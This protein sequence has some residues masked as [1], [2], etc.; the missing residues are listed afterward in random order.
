MRRHWNYF[1]CALALG[2][3]G[4]TFADEKWAWA[5]NWTQNGALITGSEG[6][7]NKLFLQEAEELREFEFEVQITPRQADVPQS[8]KICGVGLAQS[9]DAF[10][11]LNLVEQPEA[12]GNGRFMEMKLRVSGEE[13]N[14]N[15]PCLA[16]SSFPW[17]YHTAYQFKLKLVDEKI[18]GWISDGSG[19]LGEFGFDLRSSPVRSGTPFLRVDG[20]TADFA[21]P[22][23]RQNRTQLLTDIDIAL[24]MAHPIRNVDP[25]MPEY[26]QIRLENRSSAPRNVEVQL[27]LEDYSGNVQS[28]ALTLELAPRLSHTV[29]LPWQ[30]EKL[31][32]YYLY[33]RIYDAAAN[34]AKEGRLSFTVMTP[35]PFARKAGDFRFGVC[36]HIVEAK[37][38]L[39]EAEYEALAESMSGADFVR[40][41][42]PWVFFQPEKEMFDTTTWDTYDAIFAAHNVEQMH[43]IGYTPLWAIAKGYKPRYQVPGCDETTTHYALP[44]YDAYE[45]FVKLLAASTKGRVTYFE[46]WNEPDINFFS[47]FTT[48]EYFELQKR[49]Y[50]GI[51]AGNPDA[52]V[53]TGGFAGLHLTPEKYD[54]VQRTAQEMRDYFDVFTIHL[55]GTF[56]S[57]RAQIP[58]MLEWLK[59]GDGSIAP[60]YPHETGMPALGGIEAER[61][62]ART[63][64]KKLLYSWA[65]GAVGYSWYD[66]RDDG[67]DPYSTEHTFGLITMDF[68]PKFVFS[69]FHMLARTLQGAR[70]KRTLADDGRV[71]CYLF[72]QGDALLIPAWTESGKALLA[73][74]TDATAVESIDLMGNATALPVENGHVTLNCNTEPQ[75]IR[76]NKAS[77]FAFSGDMIKFRTEVIYLPGAENRQTLEVYNPFAEARTLTLELDGQR[78]ATRLQSG[79]TQAVEVALPELTADAG[80]LEISYRWDDAPPATV[81]FAVTRAL[82]V[83][84]AAHEAPDFVLD[85]ETQICVLVPYDP[86]REHLT[87][88]GAD[89]LSGKFWLHLAEDQLILRGEVVDDVHVQR[90]TG[91]DIWQSDSIQYIFAFAGQQGFFE[92]G[93]A[94]GEE[95]ESAFIWNK[96]GE[97]GLTLDDMTYKIVREGNR[98]IYDVAIPLAKLDVDRERLRRG[99]RFNV[100]INDDDG[101]GR[102]NGLYAAPGMGNDQDTSRFPVIVIE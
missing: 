42:L 67:T 93:F 1:L 27:K 37:K 80:E 39:R 43:V 83:A 79:E 70:F 65:N 68:Q 59:R 5:A 101:A 44:D 22:E 20:V 51:K 56:E 53:M 102:K 84:A 46:P 47:N 11:S 45:N 86:S 33:Y 69:T 29:E 8:W 15:L 96:P 13:V 89:D 97:A 2:A 50:R 7:Q 92:F 90:Y 62:Q 72:A 24:Q 36:S 54:I 38:P 98:T 48:E 14:Q 32:A 10:W 77:G 21:Q 57:Y 81:K 76:L 25:Q 87:W 26:P 82:P 16:W 4:N 88:H 66:L 99:F 41:A 61:R 74:R 30:P 12:L 91:P 63:L 49:A 17:E 40:E 55:H 60:W 78:T 6:V 18:L 52:Q 85:D 58:Q 94:R 3:L 95:Q 34:A 9:D 31:G 23:L 71:F 19:R 64:F 73:F 35:L 75:I 28:D 100:L